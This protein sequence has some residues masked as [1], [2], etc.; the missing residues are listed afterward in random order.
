V[1]SAKTSQLKRLIERSDRTIIFPNTTFLPRN[2]HDKV[3][4]IM[5]AANGWHFYIASKHCGQL[6]PFE[7][8]K[9]IASADNSAC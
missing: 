8:R 1:F 5:S 6:L 2:Y 4:Y 7:R 3:G 9:S